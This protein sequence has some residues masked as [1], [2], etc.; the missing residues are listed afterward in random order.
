[1]PRDSQ[2]WQATT[3][4]GPSTLPTLT[5]R[6]GSRTVQG[7]FTVPA[8]CTGVMVVVVSQSSQAAAVNGTGGST[9]Y[10]YLASLT[11]PPST[12]T[13]FWFPL[14]A[15]MEQSVTLGLVTTLVLG[16]GELITMYAVVLGASGFQVVMAPPS[17]PLQVAITTP[18]PVPVS[19]AVTPWSVQDAP[20]SGLQVANV[21]SVS[22]GNGGTTTL[23]AAV[24]AK[25]IT[26]YG[27]DLTNAIFSG[28]NGAT[29]R[30]T[31]G[32]AGGASVLRL[33]NVQ[34][35]LSAAGFAGVF[36]THALWIP[37]GLPPSA[38][39]VALQLVNDA[40]ANQAGVLDGSI[41]YTQA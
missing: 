41:Y 5:L 3:D 19:Q 34:A 7:N 25:K 31:I 38:V 28:G 14:V 23:I 21:Q 35:V 27:W 13:A 39:N 15:G 2:D 12:E 36:N 9:G 10:P 29:S 1:M 6:T 20:V 8:T 11:A 33:G 24:A 17:Q 37:G 22:I 40:G 32:F 16:A 26:V 18:S 4:V 30:G